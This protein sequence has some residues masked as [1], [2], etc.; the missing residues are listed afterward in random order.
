MKICLIG[1]SYPF[2]GGIAHHTTL[3]YRN[4]RKKHDVTFYAFKRQYPRWMFPGRTDVDKSVTVINEEGIEKI[5][6]SLNPLSWWNVFRRIK[7]VNPDLVIFPWWV[8]FWTLQFGTIASLVRRYT[9]AKVLFIC[10][11]VIA[12]ESRVMDGLFTKLVLN[13]GDYFIVHSNEDLKNLKSALPNANVKK[14]FHPTYDVFH[15]RN[16]SKEYAQRRLNVDGNILLFFGFVRPYK[17]LRY[18][19]EALPL[20]LERLDVTLLVVGEFWENKEHYIRIIKR[21]GIIDKI[22]IVDEYVPNEDVGI[23][24]AASDIVVL[25]YVSGTG[26]GIVQIAFAFN[27]PVVATNVGCLPEVIKDGKTGYLVSPGSAA[28]IANV[29]VKFFQSKKDEA[30]RENVKK[31]NFRFSWD[32][33]VGAIEELAFS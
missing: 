27:K 13:R 1:P 31:E 29:I 9:K 21:L 18:L 3:L 2:R 33:L 22:K 20:I 24:F 30:F 15:F 4:L 26:S 8:S 7:K 14:T 12:H 6:D 16:I 28:E 5:L 11:N 10:H 23:Y 32:F 25:P 17:G 19:I